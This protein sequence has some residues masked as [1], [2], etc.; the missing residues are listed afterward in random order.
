MAFEFTDLKL[1]G[2]IVIKPTVYEDPR[3]C[4]I[5][6]YK[7]SEFEKNGITEKFVQDNHSVSTFSVLRGLH[8]QRDPYAQGK[9]VRVIRGAAWDVA[10][11]LRPDSPTYG[12]WEA[13]ELSESNRLMLYIP[14]GFAHG[15]LSLSDRT[16]LVYKCTAEYSPANDAGIR[17][18]DPLL[19]IEWPIRKVHVS[20]KDGSLP[21][22]QP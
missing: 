15:F 4:F 11:D 13:L 2:A 9:L 6:S 12:K 1:H 14:V 7:K 19:G 5:E 22:F 8:F 10:V 21:Y 16:E 17:W 3:G 20:S 18:D